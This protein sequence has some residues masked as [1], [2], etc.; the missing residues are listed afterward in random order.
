[1]NEMYDILLSD[2]S[3]KEKMLNKLYKKEA[4]SAMNEKSPTD[5]T[6]NTTLK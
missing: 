1:M 4:E 3:E 2:M 5:V 6:K